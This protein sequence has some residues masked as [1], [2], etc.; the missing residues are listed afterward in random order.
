MPRVLVTPSEM[1]Y[2]QTRGRTLLEQAGFEVVF[3]PPGIDLYDEDRLI[4]HLPGMDAMLAGMEPLSQ[5]VLDASQLR[6]IARFGVGYDAIDVAA[7]RK[8]GIAVA[9]TPG[10]N[11]VSAAEHTMALLL[12]VFRQILP[13]DTSVRD[14]SWKRPWFPR[15]AGKT[16]GLIG[17]GRIG[18]EV[19]P[20][21]QAFG[22]QVI[23]FDPF[24]DT[25][26]ARRTGVQLMPLK[27]ILQ[28]SDILSLHL[29]CSES[30]RKMINR[31]SLTLMRDGAVLINTAR[32][33]LVDESALV[34]ALQSGK[35]WA[36]GIDAFDVEPPRTDHPLLHLP[37]VVLTPHTAGL[38]DDSV[39]GMGT[40]ASEW[41]VKLYQGGL[42]PA[43]SLMSPESLAGWTW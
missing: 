35:L 37:N 32:G 5:R 41:L 36:A 15:L 10:V 11:Q 4:Q 3:P 33:G 43:D 34:E 9:I 17:L 28:Q 40:R 38:D 27:D 31:E 14:G 18:R 8:K 24:P 6:A 20:R 19:V 16:L 29:P 39:A 26:F 22:L 7:A 42:V 2:K 25:N 13:R 1:L 30:S 21:A 23:A 12:A